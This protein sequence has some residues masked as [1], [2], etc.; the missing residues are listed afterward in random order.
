M[1]S[2]LIGVLG[3]VMAVGVTPAQ[4]LA[5]QTPRTL[6]DS[7]DAARKARLALEAAVERQLATTMVER[8]RTL[9]MSNE[10]T[11][12]QQLEALLDSAQGRLLVQRDRIRLLRDAA[13]RTDKAILVILV[14]VENAPAG[15]FDVSVAINGENQ[16]PVNIA[17]ERARALAAGGAEEIYRAEVVPSEHRISVSLVGP[18]I[19]VTAPITLPTTLREI[20]YVEFSLK[21]GRLVPTTWTSRASGY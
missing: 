7:L 18:G 9:A 13:T 19:A 6:Q 5:A 11:A 12:L 10:A 1:R 14:R 16:A 15:S 4:P 3:V 21:A 8:A 2:R 17:G 20:R